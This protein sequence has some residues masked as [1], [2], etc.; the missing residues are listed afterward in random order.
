VEKGRH[1]S[2]ITATLLIDDFGQIFFPFL[3]SAF[4]PQKQC[5]NCPRV[6]RGQKVKGPIFFGTANSEDEIASGD[7][8]GEIVTAMPPPGWD[9]D[10]V[11]GLK[12]GPIVIGI[13][14][15]KSRTDFS[16]THNYFIVDLKGARDLMDYLPKRDASFLY[17]GSL[18]ATDA[19]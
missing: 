8:C 13:L 1:L 4:I 9:E 16:F 2:Q 12:H 15:V 3:G 14:V 18:A 7:G 5:G 6:E 10:D 11:S 17:P 19:G